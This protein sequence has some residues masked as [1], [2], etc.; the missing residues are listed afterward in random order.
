MSFSLKN[1][2]ILWV[3][4]GSKIIIPIV[5]MAIRLY[6]I[7]GELSLYVANPGHKEAMSHLVAD[8]CSLSALVVLCIGNNRGLSFEPF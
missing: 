3:A 7:K 8:L 1:P 4:F 2:S 6:S 5:I